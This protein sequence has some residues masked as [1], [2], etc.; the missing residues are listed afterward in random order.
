M[1][2]TPLQPERCDP[3]NPEAGA[4]RGFARR[5]PDGRDS[6]GAGAR[7]ESHGSSPPDV[8]VRVCGCAAAI[9]T[10]GSMLAGGLAAG[11]A[12]VRFTA[13]VV[14]GVALFLRL[15]WVTMRRSERGV[16]DRRTH[17]LLAAQTLVSLLVNQEFM[18]L[19]ALELPLVLPLRRALW[20]AAASVVARASAVA[21]NGALLPD[22]FVASEG[23]A[24]LPFVWQIALTGF[25]MAGWQ[26][27]AF[28]GGCLAAVE[29]RHRRELAR[30]NAEMAAA[31]QLLAHASRLD[32][33]VRIARDLH[34][35]LGHS[36][37]ALRLHLDLAQ[38][39]G[40]GHG[41]AEPI[42][43]AHAIAGALLHDVRDVVASLRDDERAFDL[44]VALRRM[45]A[46]IVEP[47]V[48]L[49]MPE[50]LTVASAAR[51]HVIFRA[52]QEAITNAIRHARAT[53]VWIALTDRDGAIELTIR[54]DGEGATAV[55]GGS[56]LRGLRERIREVRGSLTIDAQPG[57][58]FA[59]Q[60]RLPEMAGEA[61]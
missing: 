21:A 23:L 48:H 53:N 14:A 19:V 55:T 26:A 29:R 42:A 6:I 43:Q 39:T 5:R 25:A 30:A 11:H 54:D 46:T 18:Y 52:V 44:G 58:G 8:W 17:L 57:R 37:T 3:K 4:W 45:V 60:V 49:S 13:V 59:L 15:F 31:H 28:C 24:H 35:A 34:D 12:P 32:E 38:R 7:A 36:L 40:Q 56:G 33:R 9:I 20:W 10:G 51:A 47:A 61:R 2:G 41:A 16:V 50:D 22:G 27:F 1:S